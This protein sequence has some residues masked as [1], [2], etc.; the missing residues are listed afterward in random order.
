[1]ALHTQDMKTTNASDVMAVRPTPGGIGP[2]SDNTDAKLPYLIGNQA[3]GFGTQDVGIKVAKQGYDARTAT[4]DQLV[5]S[6]AFN[7]FK[8]IASGLIAV[9]KAAGVKIGSGSVDLT[10][11]GLTNAPAYM[12]YISDNLGGVYA[13]QMP[14]TSVEQTGQITLNTESLADSTTHSVLITTPT[15]SSLIAT[16]ITWYIKYYIFQETAV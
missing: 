11:L 12:D 8:I 5:M 9:N 2:V 14:Y 1:M 7:M 16:D 6:S 4:S 3:G 13:N 10:S 15:G